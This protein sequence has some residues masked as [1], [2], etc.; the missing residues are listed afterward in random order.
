[1]K[2]FIVYFLSILALLLVI[3]IT[4]NIVYTTIYNTSRD[5]N[6]IQM[7]LNVPPK[8]Y[9]AIFIGSSRA[10]AQIVTKMFSNIGL[11]TYN[12]G[13]SGASLCDTS[14]LLKLFFEKGNTT[15][16]VLLELDLNYMIEKPTKGIKAL[17]LPYSSSN[18]TIRNHYV[19]N[20]WDSFFIDNL[21]FYKYC[22]Y[23]SK[24]GF[25]ELVMTLM[26][27]KSRFI[28]TDGF[29]P[30]EGKSNNFVKMEL[31][32]QIN[33]KNRYYSEIKT[34]CK[35]RRVKLIS[36]TTPICKYV[37]NKDFFIKLKNKIPELIDYS[38]VVKSDNLF[39]SCKHLN[40]NGAKIFTKILINE[41]FKYK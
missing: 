37:N 7:I 9:D 41:N 24:I 12:F 27:K 17:S 13:M 20:T 34:T 22:I 2:K 30:L 16:K 6:K 32:V 28:K 25:R 33:Q 4:L 19:T 18:S 10:E 8:H 14:L 5:R 31:P 36:F 35:N 39:Y 21:P 11:T 40:E 23:D 38:D 1:M 3:S 29:K 15:D 26:H